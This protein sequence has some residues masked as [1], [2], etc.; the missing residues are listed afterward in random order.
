M[1]GVTPPSLLPLSA[2]QYS[3]SGWLLERV[4][5]AAQSGYFR[6]WKVA[7]RWDIRYSLPLSLS[8]TLSL[9]PFLPLPFPMTRF[10]SSYWNSRHSMSRMSPRL[11]HVESWSSIHWV[12]RIWY[13][14]V[15][16]PI[17]PCSSSR[18]NDTLIE[19]ETFIKRTLKYY[20]FCFRDSRCRIS[21]LFSARTIILLFLYSI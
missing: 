15:I 7:V 16:G 5:S 9:P 2:T 4:G 3:Y 20:D 8:F 1:H 17:L 19:R 12:N 21:N 6:N 10:H 14:S 11:T 18:N 13:F